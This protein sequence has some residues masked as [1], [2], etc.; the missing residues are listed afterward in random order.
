MGQQVDKGINR[1]RTGSSGAVTRRIGRG[2]SDRRIN[3]A[4]GDFARRKIRRPCAVGQSGDGMAM[5]IHADQNLRPSLGCAG[6][7]DAIGTFDKVYD[8]VSFD[9]G[10]VHGDEH[11]GV[12]M[13]R[14][15]GA[16]SI[17]GLI[18]GNRG[19]RGVISAR[20]HFGRRKSGRPSAPGSGD[21]R[22]ADAA[23]GDDNTGARLCGAG[24]G[25]ACGMFSRI[26]C[27]VATNRRSGK[28]DAGQGIHGKAAGGRGR[29]AV[30]VD[31]IHRDSLFI[32]ATRKVGCGNSHAPCGAGDDSGIGMGAHDHGHGRSG[33]RGAGQN[34]AR[35]SFGG[36]NDTVAANQIFVKGHGGLGIDDQHILDADRLGAQG[37][38]DAHL[39]FVS[40]SIN[41]GGGELHGPGA[42]GADHHIMRGIADDDMHGGPHGAGAADIH[43]IGVI[44]GVDNM[45]CVLGARQNV[46]NRDGRINRI[47]I[48]IGFRSAQ[49]QRAQP[50][51]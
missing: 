30:V 25:N 1:H 29:I 38:G 6:Q 18:G 31:R 41:L 36:I 34:R 35:R 27:A 50:S 26:H 28:G 22:M 11:F 47:R 23:H 45:A 42:I 16:G 48:G 10:G 12:D 4:A 20:N 40:A 51:P 8:A 5:A 19:D 13:N 39:D 15:A 21:D 46:N 37:D 24:D 17:A 9:P 32:F 33:L 49:H 44:G 43:A 14:A 2:D 7:G 3:L